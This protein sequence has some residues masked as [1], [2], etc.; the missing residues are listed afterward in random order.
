[1]KEQVEELIENTDCNYMI[2]AFAWGT[3][4]HQQSL[5]SLRLFAKEVMPAFTGTPTP[6]LQK[7]A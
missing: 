2:F 3:L 6:A 7:S 4:T 1:V 5:H